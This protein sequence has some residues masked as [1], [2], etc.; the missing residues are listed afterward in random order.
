MTKSEYEQYLQSDHWKNFRKGYLDLHPYCENCELPRWL[1]QIT[2]DQDLH[3]HHRTYENIGKEQNSDMQ[4]LC[5]RCHEIETFGRS[6]LRAPKAVKC[7]LCGETH[8]NPRSEY[9]EH[10]WFILRGY[11]ANILDKPHP[12]GGNVRAYIAKMLVFGGRSRV[13]E[14]GMEAIRALTNAIERIYHWDKK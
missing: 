11:F 13:V 7:T 8:W 2:Y 9:C 12:E 10:C 5:R 3:V 14:N 1:A 6:D 4:S